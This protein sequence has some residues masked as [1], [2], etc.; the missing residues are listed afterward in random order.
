MGLVDATVTAG[1]AFGGDHEAVTTASA[2]AVAAHRAGATANTQQ[3]LGLGLAIVKHVLVRHGANLEIISAP[4]KG[5]RFICHFPA[6]RL[7]VAPV[8]QAQGA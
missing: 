3:G 1:H 5:S 2:L 4:G 7:I 6:G 8:Q